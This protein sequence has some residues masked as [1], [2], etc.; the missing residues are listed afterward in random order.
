MRKNSHFGEGN[1]ISYG[2]SE[3]QGWRV[4]MEDAYITE[5]IFDDG[6]SL[7]AIF[8]GHGGKEVAAFCAEHFGPELKKTITYLKK[9][10]EDALKE[11]CLKM[12][13]LLF[14]D[15]GQNW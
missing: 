12:D 9:N 7:F 11:T 5:P 6:I 1:N 3:M 13:E 14:S 2:V 8:D 4:S 10:Y 15:Y